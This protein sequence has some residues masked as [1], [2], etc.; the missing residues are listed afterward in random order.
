[1][2]FFKRIGDVKGVA[3]FLHEGCHPQRA[4]PVAGHAPAVAQAADGK[5]QGVVAHGPAR[6]ATTGE[7][8]G[9]VDMPHFGALL[10]KERQ[11]LAG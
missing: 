4:K 7:D 9:R 2:W 10:L 5:Q 6:I 8:E 1:L 3:E 11:R